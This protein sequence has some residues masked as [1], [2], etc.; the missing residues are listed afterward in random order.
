MFTVMPARWPKLLFMCKTSNSY[1]SKMS[2]IHAGY[3]EQLCIY[4]IPTTHNEHGLVPIWPLVV[5]HS[6]KIS[7]LLPKICQLQL[8]DS[9]KK[10]PNVHA[11]VW[12]K[13]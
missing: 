10:D 11:C 9:K 13:V 1:C 4:I 6:C 5:S 3:L 8:I 2:Q 7:F 12:L